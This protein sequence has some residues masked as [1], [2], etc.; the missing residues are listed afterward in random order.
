MYTV[1]V[2]KLFDTLQDKAHIIWDWNGTLLNDVQHAID[3]MNAL[4]AP[5]GLPLLDVERYREHFGFPIRKYYEALGFDLEAESFPALCD[6]YVAA[7]MEKVRDCPLATGSRELLQRIKQS[8]KTQSL[9]SATHQPH[10]HQMV[11]SF[12]LTRYFDFIFGIEDKL[13]ASKV[14]R[15]HELIALSGI[16]ASK[17]ILIGD[18]DHDLEVAQALNISLLLIPNGHQ[19]A[20]RLRRLHP[21]VIEVD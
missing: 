11:D 6:T 18:T 5:R 17:T 10:L 7:F 4:L 20:T 21:N 12:E 14:R 1:E 19:S 16:P 8:G 9:L 15:G 13:A 3:T 2:H